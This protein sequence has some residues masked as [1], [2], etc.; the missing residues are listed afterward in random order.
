MMKAYLEIILIS[1]DQN[2]G[3]TSTV[4]TQIIEFGDYTAYEVFA[5][6]MNTYESVQNTV[7]YRHLVQLA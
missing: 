1:S 4:H 7:I 2:G 3:E 5:N 6:Q